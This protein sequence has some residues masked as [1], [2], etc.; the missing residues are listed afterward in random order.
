[1][2]WDIGYSGACPHCGASHH[3]VAA[4]KA[5]MTTVWLRCAHCQRA[6]ATHVVDERAA[7]LRAAPTACPGCAGPR[8]AW[9]ASRCARCGHSGAGDYVC[10][11]D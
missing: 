1:M 7:A 8:E 9:A 11:A 2:A 4:D 3:L 5:G 10:S 6:A